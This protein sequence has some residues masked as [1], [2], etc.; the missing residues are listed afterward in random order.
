MPGMA[1]PNQLDRLEKMTGKT[2]D[3]YFLQLMLRH[4]IAGVEM[5]QYAAAHAQH[6]YVRNI[7]QKMVDNQ[8]N[9]ITVM[10]QMLTERGAQPL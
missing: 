8:N 2:L 1:T 7:A 6:D 5:A 4:H 9:E 3:V 10:K